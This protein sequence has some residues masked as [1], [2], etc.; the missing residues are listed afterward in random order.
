[1]LAEKKTTKR[2]QVR[3]LFFIFFIFQNLQYLQKQSSKRI[4]RFLNK[5]S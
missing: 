1:M 4:E 3:K 5:N 2:T